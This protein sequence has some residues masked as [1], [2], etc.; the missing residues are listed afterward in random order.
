[1]TEKE[2][3]EE[4]SYNLKELLH[5]ANMTQ[6]ELSLESGLADSTISDYM[7]GRQMPGVRAIINIAYALS[8]D[9]DELIDFG[10]TITK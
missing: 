6:H 7:N 3:L 8:V 2:W 10:F 9:T 5:K 4:F 1:M